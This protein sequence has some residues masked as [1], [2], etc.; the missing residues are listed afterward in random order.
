MSLKFEISSTEVIKEAADKIKKKLEADIAKAGKAL[1][2]G[3]YKQA[4]KLANNL[5]KNLSSIYNE[6]LYIEEVSDN[7]TVVGIRENASW[8]EHGYKGGFMEHLLD[9]KNG[10][11]VK[12]SKDGHRYR[13]IPFK[14]DTKG[15]K[16]VENGG[17]QLINDVKTFLRKKNLPYSKT[18]SLSLDSNG[19]PRIGK[20]HSFNIKDMRIK[21]KKGVQNLSPNMQGLTVFQNM[22]QKTGKVERNIMTFRVISDKHK[23]SKWQRDS[24]KGEKILEQVHKW[25]ENKWKNE[26]LPALKDKYEK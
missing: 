10:S 14:H 17:D 3:A 26:L 5:P 8:I 11:K 25:I 15:S 22:N 23:G 19:S 2:K 12:R 4:Q 21:T 13:V 24:R 9:P 18:R 6:N 16:S 20:I 1:G 7:I